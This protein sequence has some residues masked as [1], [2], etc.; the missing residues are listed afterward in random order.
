MTLQLN[1]SVDSRIEKDDLDMRLKPLTFKYALR[2]NQCSWKVS[3]SEASGSIHLDNH[4][5]LC[6]L[7]KQ[8]EIRWIRFT[9]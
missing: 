5:M 3:F 7:C 4:K 6:P 9:F 1:H 8:Q 2:C